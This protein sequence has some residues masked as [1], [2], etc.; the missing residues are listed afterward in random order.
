MTG[1][2]PIASVCG[3]LVSEPPFAVPPLSTALTVTI[4]VPF[5]FAA[6]VK[7]S[8]PVGETA[9]PPPGANSAGFELVVENVTVCPVSEAGPAL[10]FVA[11][12]G[13]VVGPASSSTVLSAP[14][15]KEG[16]L[17]GASGVGAGGAGG[18]SVGGSSEG[19]SG[20]LG[21]GGGAGGLGGGGGC[22]GCVSVTLT[23]TVAWPDAP[24]GSEAV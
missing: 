9:G 17:F 4:A 6:G 16:A 5:A 13:T 18:G 23:S 15:V 3:G 2:T 14:E 22:S 10:T 12:P 1:V 21:G 24:A 8:V 19:G 20:T 7:V 11:Q